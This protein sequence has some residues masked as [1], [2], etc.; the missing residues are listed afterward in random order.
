MASKWP[1]ARIEEVAEKIAMG[2]FGSSIKVETFVSSGVPVI[3]GQHLQGSRIDDGIAF[4]FI[5]ESHADRLKSANVFRGDVIFTHA[6]SIGQVAFVPKNSLYEKYVISQRQFYMRCDFGKVLP[7]YVVAYFKTPE[8]QHKLL[9]N[10]SQ[11][12]VPSI[13][14]PVSY[15]R[16]VEIPVPPLPQQRAITKTLSILDEKIGVNRRMSEILSDMVRAL[17]K[18]WFIS[19]DPVRQR[20]WG[21]RSA[22][23][24]GVSA[25]F[26]GAFIGTV[27]GEIPLGWRVRQIA[28]LADVVG[29]STPNTSDERNWIQGVH[30]WATPKD[31]SKIQS[32]VLLDTGRRVSDVGLAQIGSGL[33]PC[34]TVLLSSRAP[35]GY[36]AI[37]EIP[38]AINQGFIAMKPKAGVPS[39]FLLW[40]AEFAHNEILSR[41]NGS[42]FLEIS[43]T[44]FRSIPVVVPPQPVLDAFA[45][46]VDPMYRRIVANEREIATLTEIRDSL[47]PKLISG[48]IFVAGV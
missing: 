42:T 20:A 44:N 25:L 29:G 4:N 45:R 19:F 18:S 16:K 48:E 40:W 13:A 31:L 14:Q 43:K 15:L 26:P 47:L 9:A 23:R 12:G 27:C 11:T 30:A 28:E 22:D 41:A 5:T 38:V 7:E 36:R 8:G 2:P 3:S 21:G 10:T 24:L 33:L 6:G 46:M 35:I 34:G 37:A 1:H 17:F 32:P 39:T